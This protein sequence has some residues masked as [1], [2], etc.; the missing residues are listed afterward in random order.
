MIFETDPEIEYKC[1]SYA[2][3]KGLTNLMRFVMM[4]KQK[5][6]FNILIRNYIEKHPEEINKK[7][8]EIMKGG[9][10]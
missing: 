7:N 6:V 9:Q 5:P 4:T 8:Y 3:S 2:K 10:L 1:S